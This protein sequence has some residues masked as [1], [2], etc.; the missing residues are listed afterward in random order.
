[1]N[2]ILWARVRQAVPEAIQVPAQKNIETGDDKNPEFVT[3][4]S[5]WGGK[6]EG[7][8]ERCFEGTCNI[9][10]NPARFSLFHEWSKCLRL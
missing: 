9:L 8:R 10:V 6:H 2:V 4:Y 1:M 7:N 3:K 5:N